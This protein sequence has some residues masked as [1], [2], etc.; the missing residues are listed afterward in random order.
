MSNAT[1]K[2]LYSN[3]HSN[4]SYHQSQMPMTTMNGINTM[5]NTPPVNVSN[6]NNINNINPMNGMNNINPMN[7]ISAMYNKQ[8]IRPN[9][10]YT[11]INA[12]N[13]NNLN[14][15]TP[16]HPNINTNCVSVSNS[17]ISQNINISNNNNN[18]N[19]S[20]SIR[21]EAICDKLP[22]ATQNCKCILNVAEAVK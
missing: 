16:N 17:N 4:N 9:L 1:K 7:N 8:G 20:D 12:N 18:N 14:M 2:S 22:S 6:V 11:N 3:Q 5:G 13:L 10:D 21:L 15:N 19:F